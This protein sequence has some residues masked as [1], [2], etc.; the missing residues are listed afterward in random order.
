MARPKGTAQML[1]GIA[2][3]VPE[4]LYVRID[5]LYKSVVNHYIYDSLTRASF[6]RRII[7]AGLPVI[8]LEEQQWQE[9]EEKRRAALL[10]KKP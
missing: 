10:A 4:D 5:R 2:V 1:Y 6:V 7:E 8:E 9:G 3:R